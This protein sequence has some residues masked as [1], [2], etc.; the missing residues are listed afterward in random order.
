MRRTL[1]WLAVTMTLAMLILTGCTQTAIPEAPTTPTA[2]PT[3][4]TITDMEGRQVEIPTTVKSV[5]T[6]GSVPV[7]NSFIY[8]VG[9]GD[10]VVNNLPQHFVDRQQWKYQYVFAPQIETGPQVEGSDGPLTE[11][12]LDIDP[13]IILTMQPDSVEPLEDL[14]LTVV[15][16]Q[17]FDDTDVKNVIELLGDIL[18][19][20]E[21]ATAY[22]SYFDDSVARV[23]QAVKTAAAD[24]PRT[25]IYMNPDGMSR[26][27]LIAEWWISNAG[28]TSVTADQTEPRLKFNAEQLISW[29]PDVI[30]VSSAKNVDE[31]MDDPR[32][33]G[34]T[35]VK[36]SE[37]YVVP[38]GAHL[39]GNRT[40]E[41][42]LT[43]WF[44][45]SK[46]YPDA[47]PYE[48]FTTEV[49]TFYADIFNAEL[50]PD[51]VEEIAS[52]NR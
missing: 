52:G 35:A 21:G 19:S 32:F 36:N 23:N 31:V 9:R 34:L 39:W 43:V 4:R 26:P 49:G 37:I 7:L 42:P 16:L 29:D 8:A 46:L 28:G 11:E 44:A 13:D 30:F 18:G 45:A 38:I 15:V 41:Q 22:T 47:V 51:Q 5:V 12:L 25:A 33:V 17:W 2:A 27:H 3:S 40:S 50:T 20:P 1:R 10:V 24:S 48:T 14:G 6:I